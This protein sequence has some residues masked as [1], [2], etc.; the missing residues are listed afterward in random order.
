M[1]RRLA[2][3]GALALV[4]FGTSIGVYLGARE[5]RKEHYKARYAPEARR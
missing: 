3:L 2:C 5:W 4:A 1:R